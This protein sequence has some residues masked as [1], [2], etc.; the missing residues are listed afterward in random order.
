MVAFS[1]FSVSSF[2]LAG[3]NPPYR[4][5]H[6]HGG[7]PAGAPLHRPSVAATISSGTAEYHSVEYEPDAQAAHAD[8]TSGAL[9]PRAH[10]SNF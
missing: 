4:Y 10:G 7:T 9:S 3:S 8:N 5:I 1:N 2:C 6:S